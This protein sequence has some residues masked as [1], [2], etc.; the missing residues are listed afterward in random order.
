MAIK[1]KILKGKA[2]LPENDPG[3]GGLGAKPGEIP[4]KP[5]EIKPKIPIIQEIKPTGILKNISYA[6]INFAL[7][8]KKAMIL[9]EDERQLLGDPLDRLEVEI[10]RVL[11]DYLKDQLL[12]SGPF[13][14]PLLEIGMTAMLIIDRRKKP[15]EPKKDPA[16]DISV[17]LP[18]KEEKVDPA[19]PLD[20]PAATQQT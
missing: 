7:A 19:K 1:E 20:Q 11:P 15:A 16:K 9:Q 14:G 3:L 6:G 8:R 18:A 4:L 12:K 10:I 2:N 17:D 5:R 13:S